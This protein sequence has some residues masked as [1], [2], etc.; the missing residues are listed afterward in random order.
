[1]R[2][3]Y[4]PIASRAA[5]L[6]NVLA[7]LTQINHMYQFSLEWFI[8]K[9]IKAVLLGS[10][11]QEKTADGGVQLRSTVSRTD[12]DTSDFSGYLAS[13]MDLITESIYKVRQLLFFFYNRH[14]FAK[15]VY[16]GQGQVRGD[17]SKILWMLENKDFLKLFL[18][19]CGQFISSPSIVF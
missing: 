19:P 4:L 6:Y 18:W 8:D 3:K 9:Y 1:M 7:D 2:R 17:C 15:S 16:I 10:E 12:F 5:D 14:T 11:A 13:V